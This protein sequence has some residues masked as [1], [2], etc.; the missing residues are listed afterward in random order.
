M[1]GKYFVV[2]REGKRCSKGDF[3]QKRQN[4]QDEKYAVDPEKEPFLFSREGRGENEFPG[5]NN[6]SQDQPIQGD[7]TQ[8]K[9]IK[10]QVFPRISLSKG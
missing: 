9:I 2:R 5:K 8:E 6:Q 4:E 1:C 3:Y 7:S 10:L